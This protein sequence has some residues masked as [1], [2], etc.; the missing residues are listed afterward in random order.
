MQENEAVNFFVEFS[1][2]EAIL[3]NIPH[4]N[5]EDKKQSNKQ[6]LGRLFSHEE[7]RKFCSLLENHDWVSVCTTRPELIGIYT[8]R[9]NYVISTDN[10]ST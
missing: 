2:H 6:K 10:L 7:Q 1:D 3:L 5:D 8:R 9:N 4:N